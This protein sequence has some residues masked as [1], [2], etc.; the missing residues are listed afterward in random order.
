MYYMPVPF[1]PVHLLIHKVLSHLL[2]LLILT[3]TYEASTIILT[4][5][6][7][8]LEPGGHKAEPGEKLRSFDSSS[9]AL[10]PAREHWFSSQQV[11]RFSKPNTSNQALPS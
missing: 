3:M 10:S 11:L 6:I 8:R 4:P 7:E 2:F 1:T 9:R 5:L